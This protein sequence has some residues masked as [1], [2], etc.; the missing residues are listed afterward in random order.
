MSTTS[1]DPL[2]AAVSSAG[3]TWRRA[4]D[5]EAAARSKR[6]EAIR[7]AAAGGLG[8]REIARLAQV[9]A[10]QVSRVLAR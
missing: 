1:Q 7:A 6:D 3:A 8:V 9:D 2:I 5:R 4:A 10:T